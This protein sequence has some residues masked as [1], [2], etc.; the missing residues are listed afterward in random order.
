MIGPW[1]GQQLSRR[2]FLIIAFA[3]LYPL[4]LAVPFVNG[5]TSV[6]AR[7][8]YAVDL[9]GGFIAMLSISSAITQLIMFAV[10]AGLTLSLARKRLRLR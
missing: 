4:S 9:A 6:I 8:L 7:H 2:S 1:F 3:V 5:L 10:L